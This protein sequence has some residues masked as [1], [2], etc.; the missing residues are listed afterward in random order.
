MDGWRNVAPKT[1][2]VMAIRNIE[3]QRMVAR[4]GENCDVGSWFALGD[5]AI[6]ACGCGAKLFGSESMMGGFA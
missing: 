1:S 3:T 5:L 6:I 2:H 4:G